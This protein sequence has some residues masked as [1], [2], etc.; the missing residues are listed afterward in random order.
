MS[1]LESTK[2]A[3]PTVDLHYE[4]TGGTGRPVVLIHGWPLSGAA[5][6]GNVPA[7]QAAGYRVVTF[8]RRGF[9][10]SEKPLT[11]YGYDDLA[12]DVAGLIESLD[13][14]D[15]TLVGFSMGGGEVARYIAKHGEGR[16]HSVVFAAAVPPYLLNTGDNPDGPL[17]KTLAAQMTAGLTANRE[18]FFDDF[19][20]QFFSAGDQL[21]VTEEQRQEALALTRQASKPAALEAMASFAF[22]DF[23]DDL[24]KVTVP[25][26]VI[27]GDSDGTVPF[28]GSGARTH[29]ALAGSQLHLVKQGPH[30]INVSHES[31][32]NEALIKFLG[33]D[34]AA[35]VG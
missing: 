2:D 11:G 21:M 26:L 32:F 27:H 33:Q 22:T 9:G 17:S 1:T 14:T 10:E 6:K 16:L 28:E 35:T 15:V 3:L 24:E 23:R 29:E 4:D 5:W 30:G 34:T 12:D 13:L 19:M 31:E 25:A 8:D 20:T 18:S 7:L